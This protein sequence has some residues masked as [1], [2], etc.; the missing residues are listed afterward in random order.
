MEYREF[1][2]MNSNII[3]AAEGEK[4][5]LRNGFYE[6]H[7]FIER[8]EERFTRFSQQS[9]LTQLNRSSGEW[10]DASPEL[11]EVVELAIRMHHETHGLFDPGVLDALLQA[12][13]NRSMDDLRREGAMPADETDR[14]LKS[15]FT[16]VQLDSLNRRILLPQGTHIDLG[17]IAKGWIAEQ[18]AS[19]LARYSNTC[20]VSAGGDMV[21]IGLPEGE[22]TWSVGLEDPL[23]HDR[24]LAMLKVGPGAVATSSITKRRWK[25]GDQMQH[26]LID[27]RTGKPAVTDWLSVTVVSPSAA[28]AEV[29]AKALLILG[30]AEARSIDLS[31]KDIIYIAVDNSG[32]L[33]GSSRSEEILKGAYEYA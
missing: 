10:F 9:E 28:E 13:Y 22:T 18:A 6:T 14:Q 8:S 1:R 15:N 4:S 7:A 5:R 25:Q 32:K 11:F 21:L 24:D 19:L 30:S 31:K 27:P 29:Y 33:W 2:A 17:G 3:M 26:H 12:G 20:A 23:Y 16:A